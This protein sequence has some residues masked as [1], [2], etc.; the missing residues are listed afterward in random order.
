VPVIPSFLRHLP[1]NATPKDVIEATQR[2]FA[3]EAA[4]ITV[5]PI[6]KPTTKKGSK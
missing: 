1:A 4:R 3:A 6:T 2:H 5:R